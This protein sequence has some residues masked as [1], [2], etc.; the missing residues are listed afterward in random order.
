MPLVKLTPETHRQ[1]FEALAIANKA[2]AHNATTH[3]QF[4]CVDMEEIEESVFNVLNL[5]DWCMVLEDMTGRITGGDAEHL[6]VSANAAFLI[7]KAVP[8]GDR[9][10]E[11]TVLN[12][13][14]V[15]GKQ[16]LAKM[17]KDMYEYNAVTNDNIMV[18]FNPNA[19]RFEKLKAISDNCFG[20][21][22]EF[23]YS[24]FELLEYNNTLWN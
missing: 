22:F 4:V 1:Y 9:A 6:A 15:I 23:E 5:K 19:V 13:A 17:N 12:D 8:E 3:K 24:K 16:F 11:R 20:Y 10:T 21:R 14:F 7:F 18:N 2:I